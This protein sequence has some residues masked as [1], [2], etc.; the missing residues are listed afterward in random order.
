[1]AS[2]DDSQEM[3]ETFARL[4]RQFEVLQ[5][6]SQIIAEASAEIRAE[7]ELLRA[8]ARATGVELG[9]TR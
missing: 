6:Q 1:M 5:Q 3:T 2:L 4:R 9:E 8:K 7:I